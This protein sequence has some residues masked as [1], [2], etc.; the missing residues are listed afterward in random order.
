[1]KLVLVSMNLHT[2]FLRVFSHGLGAL[3]AYLG[4]RGHR[5]TVLELN[6]EHEI[7]S[8]GPRIA[9][10]SPDVVGFTGP[11]NQAPFFPDVVAATRAALP[12]AK[13]VIGGW[14]ASIHPQPTLLNSGAD[15]V[16]A[17]EGEL[18]LAA[19]LED[20]AGGGDGSAAPNLWLRDGPRARFTV[21]APF[22]DDLD[23]LPI[24]DFDCMDLE[25][26]LDVNLR[27]P[28]IVASRGCAWS[29]RFCS[30]ASLRK[31]GTGSYARL[32]SVQH[33][34]AEVD[35]LLERFDPPHLFF[36]DDTF[37]WDRSWALELCAQL[38]ARPR[39]PSFEILT[40]ADCLDDE[41]I[42]ALAHAG[43]SCVWLGIDAGDAGLRTER[44]GKRVS[45]ECIIDTAD[46]LHS[47]GITVMTTNM[48]GLPGET[49]A[50]HQS[51]IELNRRI[52]RRHL[53]SAPGAGSGPKIFIFGPFPGTPLYDH[54]LQ[55]GYV[56]D[57][58]RGYEIYRDTFLDM[59]QFPPARI[60]RAYRDFRY[61]VYKPSFPLR[62]WLYRAW[63]HGIGPRMGNAGWSRSQLGRL[64]QLTRSVLR[65]GRR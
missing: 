10:H 15:A 4:P 45:T 43:C 3:S 19:Y 2:P 30:N 32:R 6:H 26:I 16:I 49:P 12:N 20:L 40:R 57:Y 7:R 39:H 46:R 24:V 61:Q 42:R 62:A 38:G 18:A 64:H 23:S 28:V 51:T 60:R 44:L 50:Q 22:I 58:P 36:R 31:T 5:V 52:Y 53:A 35:L 17:G 29:C 41:L 56:S 48:V 54:C 37:T 14:H 65:V 9:L 47:A 21:R 11:A 1:M 63:D 59:P 34:M 25:G 27:V 33:V 13:I 55:R 8:L